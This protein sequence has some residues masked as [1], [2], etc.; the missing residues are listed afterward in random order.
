[1][2]KHKW[3]DEI[4]AWAGGAEIEQTLEKADG[5]TDWHDV[6]TPTFYTKG[7]KFRIKPQQ[8]PYWLC[9]G[10]IDRGHKN[11]H[12]QATYFG[13]ADE[14]SKRC[15]GTVTQKEPKY[16]YVVNNWGSIRL[17]STKELQL[18]EYCIGKIEVQND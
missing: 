11:H 9:C 15:G 8:V 17:S 10:D 12:H 14:H 13:T 5:W 6:V 3:H 7:A 4:V 16:L 1:M 2:M 18:N